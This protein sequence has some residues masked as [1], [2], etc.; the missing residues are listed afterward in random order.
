MIKSI[1]VEAPWIAVSQPQLANLMTYEEWLAPPP[2]MRLW[3]LA[4]SRMLNNGHAVMDRQE[5]L[6][7]L[8]SGGID[9]QTG[10]LFPINPLADD[11]LAR[12]AKRLINGAYITE[13][14]SSRAGKVCLVVSAAIAQRGTTTRGSNLA[15]PIHKTWRRSYS[16]ATDNRSYRPWSD[17]STGSRA[18]VLRGCAG[19]LPSTAAENCGATART[20]T[21]R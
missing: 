15:C 12:L 2:V 6:V 13:M 17:G 10:E 7:Q 3:T 20:R 21:G 19:G 9:R 5:L 18:A 8:G 4:Q 14:K 1:N 16:P 11:V